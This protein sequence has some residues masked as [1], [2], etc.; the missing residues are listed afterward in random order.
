[1]IAILFTIV[2]NTIGVAVVVVQ[3]TRVENAVVVAVE[4]D[5]L[6][7]CGKVPKRQVWIDFGEI[8]PLPRVGHAK[9]DH[10]RNIFNT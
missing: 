7:N 4:N 10:C 8:L 3:F 1:M 5:E 2:W 9:A 6:V